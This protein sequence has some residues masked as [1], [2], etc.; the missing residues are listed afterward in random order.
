MTVL[1]KNDSVE[2]VRNW[3]CGKIA[4]FPTVRGTPRIGDIEIDGDRLRCLVLDSRDI[5][6]ELSN[7]NLTKAVLF[8]GQNSELTLGCERVLENGGRVYSWFSLRNMG[9]VDKTTAFNSDDV[10]RHAAGLQKHFLRS[11]ET[12]D[13]SVYL[14]FENAKNFTMDLLIQKASIFL[15]RDSLTRECLFGMNED[16]IRRLRE[17]MKIT[18]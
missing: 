2:L 1:Q 6:Q 5:P 15:C 3:V 14:E 18:P 13:G 10:G 9:A 4:A 11:T 12:F 16:F 7:L 17:L 8:D